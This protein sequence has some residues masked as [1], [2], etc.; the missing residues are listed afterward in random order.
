MFRSICF[1]MLFL[2]SLQASYAQSRKLFLVAGQ[3][4]AVGVGNKDLSVACAAGTCFEYIA[5]NNSLKPLIDPVGYGTK[6]ED[7]Q[8]AVTGS[9]WPSFASRYHLLTG[10]TVIIVQAAKGGTSCSEKAD[11]GNGNWSASYHLFVQAVAKAK[12]AEK[13]TGLKLSGII[14]LQGESDG[15]AINAGTISACD[16]EAS[17]KNLIERFRGMFRC[18]LPFYIIQTGL[19]TPAYDNGFQ[20]A[21]NVQQQVADDDSLTFI[22]DSSAV[23]FRDAGKMNADQIH[24]N[25]TGLNSIGVNVATNSHYIEQHAPFDSCFTVPVVEYEPDWN[26][27]PSPLQPQLTVEI[28]KCACASISLQITD[29]QGRTVY[30]VDYGSFQLKQSKISIDTRSFDKGIYIVQLR[31]NGSYNFT[32]KVLKE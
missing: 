28:H 11:A 26:V 6:K 20:L 22:V 13:Y 19:F 18:N 29:M 30:H 16:Y 25:Q 14:W 5:S 32:K 15:V 3:S 24:Y 31:V 21:R 27:Y 7:F 8:A 9:C 12:G 23:T 10:D 4:N 2:C 17:F 1:V